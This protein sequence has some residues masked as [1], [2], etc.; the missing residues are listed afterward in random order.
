MNPKP[1]ETLGIIA[2]K[3][4]GDIRHLTEQIDTLSSEY[5]EAMAELTEKYKTHATPF[6]EQCREKEKTLISLMKTEKGILFDGQDIVQLKNGTLLHAII[7]K[8]HIPRNALKR[9]E[10]LEFLEAIK[11]AKSLDRGMIEKWPDAKLFL[12]GAER[13]PEEEFSYDLKNKEEL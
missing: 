6:Q 9:C 8:V 5:S 2:D 11:I 1:R 10:E 7:E 13:K 4:L 3:L 12:I